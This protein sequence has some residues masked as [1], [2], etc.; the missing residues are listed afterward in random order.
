[1]IFF[2]GFCLDWPLY[3]GILC[4]SKGYKVASP[5]KNDFFQWFYLDWPLYRGILCRSKGY[6][7]ASPGKKKKKKTGV[8]PGLATLYRHS[9]SV[10]GV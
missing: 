8:L 4:R 2:Q 1:M 10:E 7:V 3:R 5:G 9:L 6:K